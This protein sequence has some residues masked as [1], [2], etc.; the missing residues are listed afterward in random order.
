MIPPAYEPLAAPRLRA[1]GVTLRYDQRVVSTGLTV[2]IPDREFT[3]IIGRS[4]R[5]LRP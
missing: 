2:D 1:E 5:E 3:V 4:F